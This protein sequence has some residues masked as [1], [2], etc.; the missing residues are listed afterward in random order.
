MNRKVFACLIFALLMIMLT[1]IV[2]QAGDPEKPE[3]IDRIRDVKL[4]GF[5]T[6]P[7]QQEY[8]YVD[9]VAAWFCEETTN[10]DYLYVCL[11]LRDLLERTE[12]LEAIYDVFWSDNT[13]NG[14]I[15]CV[16]VN[17]TGV[18]SF[19][20]GESTDADDY[21]EKWTECE[22][23]LDAENDILTWIV[24]KQ[25]IGDPPIGWQLTNILPSTHLRYTDDSG[26]PLTDLFKDLPWNAK[27]TNNYRI[28]Y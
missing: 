3:V 26:K 10:P 8:K 5:L 25:L 6:I 16:H 27:E 4:F 17:P 22:G 24:P 2:T 23:L 20:I 15:A 21:M 14:F 18:R 28:K 9:I 7:F 13:H 19:I 12:E 11:Q 1:P